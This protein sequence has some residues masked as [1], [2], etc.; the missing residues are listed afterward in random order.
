VTSPVHLTRVSANAKTG[1][2]PVSTSSR[3][4]CPSTC[5]FKGN[6]CYAENHPLAYHWNRVTA[7][8]GLLWEDFVDEISRLK[9]GQLWRHN[10]AGD[11]AG[12]GD[13]IDAKALRQLTKANR[14]K[15]G[16]TYTHYPPTPANVKAIRAAI[17]GGFTVNLSADSLADADRLAPLGL[18]LVVVVPLGWKEGK[19]PAGRRVTLCPAQHK[20]YI[21]CAT[22]QLCQKADRHAIVA[23]EAHGARKRTVIRVLEERATAE[24]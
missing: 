6:G 9:A 17:K 24:P 16:F 3:A 15:H 19:T 4:T 8:R 7:G 11:L 20:E 14:G 21:T 18:P 1:P 12:E 22:C 13:V 5:S 2:I 10:Q 23:F